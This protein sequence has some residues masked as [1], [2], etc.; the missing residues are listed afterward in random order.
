MARE[1]DRFI[2]RL[3]DGMRDRIKAAAAENLRSMNSEVLYH[4]KRIY[5][6][7]AGPQVGAENPAAGNDKAALQG[8]PSINP[9]EGSI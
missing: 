2:I 4:L 7:A 9:D 8:G 1:D 6:S 5:G 3:P